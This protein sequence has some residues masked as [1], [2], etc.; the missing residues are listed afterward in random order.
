[1]LKINSPSKKIRIQSRLSETI[2]LA[3]FWIGKSCVELKIEIY[4]TSKG[5]FTSKIFASEVFLIEPAFLSGIP[6][7]E[8][9]RGMITL[10]VEDKFYET[11][12]ISARSKL[13]AINETLEMI[14]E[15]IKAYL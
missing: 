9:R 4:E 11:R 14:Y 5:I 8:E 12:N 1:M 2:Y 13:N 7:G 10:F 15:K 3:P 6:A